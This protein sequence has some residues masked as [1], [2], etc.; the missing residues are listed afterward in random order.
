MYIDLVLYC[1]LSAVV[2]SFVLIEC[3]FSMLIAFFRRIAFPNSAKTN[4]R[5]VHYP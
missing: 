5:I 3:D 1:L 2:W 4:E